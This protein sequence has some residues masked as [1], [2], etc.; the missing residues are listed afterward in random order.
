MEYTALPAHISA[1]VLILFL[2]YTLMPIM[3][4]TLGS[5]TIS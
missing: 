2:N 5:P 1:K 4:K 3:C